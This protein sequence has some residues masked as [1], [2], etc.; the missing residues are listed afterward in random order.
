MDVKTRKVLG[1]GLNHNRICSVMS[2]MLEDRADPF[3]GLLLQRR[4]NQSRIRLRHGNEG[5]DWYLLS[6]VEYAKPDIFSAR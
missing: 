1:D 4:P 6:D 3:D 5:L 2:A